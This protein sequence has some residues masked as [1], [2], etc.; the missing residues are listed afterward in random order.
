M[1]FPSQAVQL[2]VGAG[3]NVL[4]DGSNGLLRV[5]RLGG[6]V[7]SE[8]AG[9]YYEYARKGRLFMAS[10]QAGAAWGTA[11]ITTAAVTFT[12]A[13]PAA[14][15]VNLSLLG[16]TATPSAVEVTTALEGYY[17]GYYFSPAYPSATTPIVMYSG[18]LTAGQGTIGATPNGVACSAATVLAGKLIRV[19]PFSAV[20]FAAAGTTGY[21]ISAYDAVEGAIVLA[22]NTSVTL[23]GVGTTAIS[24]VISMVWAEMPI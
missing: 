11:L 19:H 21:G 14:S 12:L 4:A 13:N 16:V 22:P 20:S 7:G 23:V 6:V 15:P 18:L 1:A 9:K 2:L 17:L 3:E 24:G 8:G 10:M 5:D